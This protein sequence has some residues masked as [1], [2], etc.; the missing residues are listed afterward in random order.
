MCTC[1]HFCV[2]VYM[3]KCVYVHV[4]M[5]VCV[6]VYTHVCIFFRSVSTDVQI[7]ALVLHFWPPFTL[8]IFAQLF[9]GGRREEERETEKERQERGSKRERERGGERE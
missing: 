2:F 6:C 4:Y 7:L 3:N 8:R 1:V 5:N 9:F